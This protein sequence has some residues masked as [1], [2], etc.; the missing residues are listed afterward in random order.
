VK[1]GEVKMAKKMLFGM[2]AMLLT[3]SFAGLSWAS[4]VTGKVVKIEGDIYVVKDDVDGKERKIHTDQ[5]TTKEGEIKAGSKVQA[6]VDDKSGH[7]KSI[8]VMGS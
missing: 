4:I 1:G 6:D 5:T 3:F 8:K 2:L 7:A